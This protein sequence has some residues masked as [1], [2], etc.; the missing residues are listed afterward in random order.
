M[1]KLGGL[2]A[3][4]YAL[5]KTSGSDEWTRLD[6]D[7]AFKYQHGKCELCGGKVGARKG[8]IRV[9]HWYHL[10]GRG[11]CDPWHEPKGE[12]HRQI[13]CCFPVSRQEYVICRKVGDATVKHIADIYTKSGYVIEVQMSPL[14]LGKIAEREEF[15]GRIVWFVSGHNPLVENFHTSAFMENAELV[16]GECFE[17]YAVP[18]KCHAINRHWTG[19]DGLVFFD[20]DPESG[21]DFDNKDVLCLVLGMRRHGYL[22]L[23]V[24]KERELIDAFLG[25]DAQ[26]FIDKMMA[27]ADDFDRRFVEETKRAEESLD[28]RVRRVRSVEEVDE[29]KRQLKVEEWNA[30][31]D[32]RDRSI[33]GN[34]FK[35]SLKVRRWRPKVKLSER[36]RDQLSIVKSLKRFNGT[37]VMS[38][39]LQHPDKYGKGRLL[40]DDVADRLWHE[41]GCAEKWKNYLKSKRLRWWY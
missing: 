14:S 27:T 16:Q 29:L 37:A 34:R 26:G 18:E 3:M 13:Q 4:R 15:Y 33:G 12:W 5:V 38:D 41:S 25:D 24:V 11:D 20:I 19:R 40:P 23:R 17:Y 39:V 7:D 32:L 8:D 31:Q 1:K 9:N 10:D 35:M 30:S 22:I 21:V 6:V 28:L 2:C 36:H